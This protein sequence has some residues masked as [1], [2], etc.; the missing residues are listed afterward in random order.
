MKEASKEF[1]SLNY[2][3]YEIKEMLDQHGLIPTLL[4]VYRVWKSERAGK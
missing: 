3:E 2:W 4:K 1:F